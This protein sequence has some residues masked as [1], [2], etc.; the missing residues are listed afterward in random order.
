VV[1]RLYSCPAC[2][3]LLQRIDPST[4]YAHKALKAVEA[5]GITLPVHG[6]EAIVWLSL[7]AHKGVCHPELDL[8]G[9]LEAY[10]SQ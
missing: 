5:A 4:S 7:I 3:A 6:P 2:P 10:L 1:K 8:R 9:Y